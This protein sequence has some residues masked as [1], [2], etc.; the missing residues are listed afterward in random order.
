[1]KNII[2]LVFTSLTFKNCLSQNCPF[3]GNQDN[4]GLIIKEDGTLG[5]GKWTISKDKLKSNIFWDT[6]YIIVNS[7]LSL[8][9][10]IR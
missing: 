8:M 5:N 3:F 9:N 4:K 1:M 10:Y 2:Y 6:S 7:C